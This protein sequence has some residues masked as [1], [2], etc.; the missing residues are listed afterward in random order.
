MKF[1]GCYNSLIMK[2]RVL[3]NLLIFISI[4]L[5]TWAGVF[6][7]K[8]FYESILWVVVIEIILGPIGVSISGH[9]YLLSMI[10]CILIGVYIKKIMRY[11]E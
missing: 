3:Y 5:F 8:N 11:Y 7:F 1:F 6:L 10:V 2:W 9:Y 4:F